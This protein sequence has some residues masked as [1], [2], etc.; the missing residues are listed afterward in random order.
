MWR[1]AHPE[2]WQKITYLFPTSKG[3]AAPE[4][5]ARR[6]FPRDQLAGLDLVLN[7]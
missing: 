5:T 6:T 7:T 1:W 4:P 2:A 3:R